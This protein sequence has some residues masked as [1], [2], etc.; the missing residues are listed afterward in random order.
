MISRINKVVDSA[1]GCETMALLDCFS[2]YHQIWLHRKMKKNK[3]HNAL[4]YLPLPQ[5]AQRPQ[6][7]WP[8][9]L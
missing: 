4:R 8:Y 9:L 7:R 1:V 3:L 2:G 5:N 6:E